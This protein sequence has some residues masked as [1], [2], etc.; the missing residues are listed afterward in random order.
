MSSERPS[1]EAST[2]DKIAQ[3]FG[4]LSHLLRPAVSSPMNMNSSPD[5]CIAKSDA[6]Y[7]FK[8]ILYVQWLL[9]C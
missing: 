7:V 6:G 4:E 9:N 1:K 5:N 8:S 2:R 3:S